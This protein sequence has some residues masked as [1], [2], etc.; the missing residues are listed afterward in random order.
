M[1][2]Y[3][4]FYNPTKL[5]SYGKPW[6]FSLGIRS[7]G[8]ST[9]F[10]LFFLHDFIKNGHMFV[11]MR[12]DKDELHE[13]CR[14]YFDTAADI[15]RDHGFTIDD[16]HYHGG[17]YYLNGELCGYAVPLSTQQKLKSNN[18]SQVWWILY[19]EFMVMPGN[20]RGYLGGRG[21]SM[22]E[23][24]ALTSF[25][26][27]VDRG[28]GRAFR[29][30]TR[31]VFVGNA[32]TLYN[33][34]FVKE[35]IDKY[36]R[37]D[38]KYLAPKKGIY[39]LEVT[40]ETEATKHIKES[41]GYKMSTERTKA[42]A[43]ENEFADTFG[44]DAFIDREPSGQRRPLCNLIYEND[45]YGVYMYERAGYLYIGHRPC[46]G[47]KELALTTEDHRPNYLLM[48]NY[49]QDPAA[50]LIKDMYD[51]G[52]IRFADNKCKMII[53]FYLKYDQ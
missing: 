5:L 47:R 16:F 1:D 51:K 44:A 48:R 8:K 29:N 15:L 24:D 23:V 2:L 27:T 36:L 3:G 13:T 11:Y 6:N 14:N 21:N 38:T 19:D 7:I 33:P 18:Y 17:K 30:E 34:F 49:R 35:E 22:A 28:K 9:G 31:V 4:I 12:R 32:G 26:Q 40:R 20:T 41:Y 25:Y 52:A 37:P 53:D 46:Q 50:L 45:V 10:A 39:V 42:Y 43:F